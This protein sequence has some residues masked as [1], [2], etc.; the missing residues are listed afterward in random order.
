MTDNT[1]VLI[2]SLT[3]AVNARIACYYE[4]APEEA[5]FPYAILIGLNAHD[6]DAG[7]AISFY[8]E[9]YTGER[10]GQSVELDRKIDEVR[11][12][13]D[14]SVVRVAGVFGAYVHFNSRSGR[15]ENAYDLCHRRLGLTAR[16]FFAG[17]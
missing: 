1:T 6:I 8:L 14:G 17:G 16:T 3:N 9:F 11:S 15:D 5:T 2:E 10:D 4:E 13:L 7:D 12:T